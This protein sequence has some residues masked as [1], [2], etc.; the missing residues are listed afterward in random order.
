MGVTYVMIGQG[1]SVNDI[2]DQLDRT[3]CYLS[4]M[5]EEFFVIFSVSIL[6]VKVMMI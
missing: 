4:E 2:D 5:D 6:I 3:V 1:P